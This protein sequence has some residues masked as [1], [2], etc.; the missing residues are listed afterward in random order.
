[1]AH[2]QLIHIKKRED[3]TPEELAKQEEMWAKIKGS[4]SDKRKMA[5]KISH[6]PAM[7]DDNAEKSIMELVSNPTLSALQIQ[8][9]LQKA[10]ERDLSDANFLQLI[11]ILIQKHKAIFGVEVSIKADIQ[12]QITVKTEHAQAEALKERLLRNAVQEF[13]LKKVE[14]VFG[15]DKMI[16]FN[17]AIIFELTPE[18]EGKYRENALKLTRIYNHTDKEGFVN[19]Q[20][21]NY[22]PA[23]ESN[24]EKVVV[25]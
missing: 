18:I 25:L 24:K 1:M 19:K 9:L 16:E 13:I 5:Q 23:V 10:L 15:Y 2:E 3:C 20:V 17:R 14:Q 11:S 8:K 6:I 22:E 21:V 4:S 7:R 12:Q